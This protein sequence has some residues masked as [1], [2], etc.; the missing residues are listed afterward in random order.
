MTKDINVHSFTTNGKPYVVTK[1]TCVIG[2]DK[3]GCTCNGFRY[4]KTEPKNCKH[5]ELAKG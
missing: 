5:I 1:T 4:S 3:F 2:D